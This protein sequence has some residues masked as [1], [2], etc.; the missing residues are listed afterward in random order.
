MI[1][2]GSYF[3][4]MVLDH[5]P[6]LCNRCIQNPLLWLHGAF[7]KWNSVYFVTETTHEFF[8]PTIKSFVF[9]RI[10]SIWILSFLLMNSDLKNTPYNLNQYM[11]IYLLLLSMQIRR[12]FF[13]QFS[14][15]RLTKFSDI[16]F[17]IVYASIFWYLQ[18]MLKN[19]HIFKMRYIPF[20]TKSPPLAVFSGFLTSPS[21]SMYYRQYER[22]L[23]TNSKSSS[24][25]ISNITYPTAPQF[26]MKHTVALK[27]NHNLL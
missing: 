27:W 17:K 14:V 12:T 4:N 9:A 2:L 10:C 6:S 15:M 22:I 20:H 5:T 19:R 21:C 16:N 18:S 1:F 8:Q 13:S 23:S 7:N 3:L 25:E 11:E 26:Q 24:S